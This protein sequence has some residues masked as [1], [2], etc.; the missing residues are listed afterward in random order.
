MIK[1]SSSGM[2][3][4][5]FLRKLAKFLSKVDLGYLTQ[6]FCMHFKYR[7]KFHHVNSKSFQ[8]PSYQ[9]LKSPFS[10]CFQQIIEGI[11]VS[12]HLLS[13]NKELRN[14]LVWIREVVYDAQTLTKWSLNWMLSSSPS[15]CAQTTQAILRKPL[16]ATFCTNPWTLPFMKVTNTELSTIVMERQI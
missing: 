2:P 1:C 14:S 13:L 15:C 4:L 3:D 16:S 8:S 12:F 10:Y 9:I 11:V 7:P 5:A 6:S